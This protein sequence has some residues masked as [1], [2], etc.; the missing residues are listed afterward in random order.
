MCDVMMSNSYRLGYNSITDFPPEA[1]YPNISLKS[2]SM[3]G[4]NLDWR[5]RFFSSFIGVI[6]PNKTIPKLL[7]YQ[8]LFRHEIRNYCAE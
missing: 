7:I 4:D 5:T 2:T 6:S 8:H 1:G 3:W